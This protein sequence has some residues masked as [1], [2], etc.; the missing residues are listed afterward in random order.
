MDCVCRQEWIRGSA[1]T[2]ASQAK[3][4]SSDLCTKSTALCTK[5]HCSIYGITNNTLIFAL[6]GKLEGL[7]LCSNGTTRHGIYSLT[8]S[9]HVLDTVIIVS[10]V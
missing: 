9:K 5:N 10:V 6:H 8:Q 1:G 2:I 4:C 7:C 3:H